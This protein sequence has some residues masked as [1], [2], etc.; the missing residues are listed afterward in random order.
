MTKDEL[1]TERQYLS[2]SEVRV[3]AQLT[4]IFCQVGALLYAAFEYL[5]FTFS[6]HIQ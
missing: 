6:V 3:L 1:P 2:M 4:N 5:S